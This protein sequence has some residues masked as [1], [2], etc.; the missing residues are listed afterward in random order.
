[1]GAWR[2]RLGPRG[3]QRPLPRSG[4]PG[5][6]YRREVVARDRAQ[7]LR[8]TVKFVG[9]GEIA[10]GEDRRQGKGGKLGHT[11]Q[12]AGNK[13]PIERDRL[14]KHQLHEGR[15]FC[16][17]DHCYLH[18]SLAQEGAKQ[19]F[20]GLRQKREKDRHSVSEAKSWRL[21]FGAMHLVL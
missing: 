21:A 3:N 5:S 2:W 7:S 20:V 13:S 16:P 17:F 9:V 10:L 11:F 14:G 4:L 15:S 12:G 8:H 18:Q 6:G 19:V 1:M